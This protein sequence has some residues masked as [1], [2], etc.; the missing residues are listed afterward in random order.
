[1]NQSELLTTLRAS[2]L[3]VELS[4]DQAALLAQHVSMRELA[5]GQTLINE[6][7]S[8]DHL[9]YVVS[10][11]LGAVKNAGRPEQATLHAATAGDLVGELSFI[12]GAHHYASWI[13]LAPTRLVALERRQFEQ[14]LHSQPDLVYCIM[15]AIVRAVHE[16]Q[17]RLSMQA[18]ELSNYIFKQHGR[19]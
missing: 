11:V 14:L 6:G 2:R 16:I 12:D 1:M 3:G 4:D 9:Y 18:V 19:Y 10:G 13:A 17:R 15:R 5:Q 8:D 7:E